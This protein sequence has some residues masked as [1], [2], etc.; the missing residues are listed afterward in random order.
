MDTP[1][2]TTRKLRDFQAYLA[3]KRYEF[4]DRFDPSDLSPKFIPYYESGQRIIVRLPG[5][6]E[7]RGYVHI[8]TGWKP[9]FL[10]IHRRSDL[11][12][13]TL[14]RDSYTIVGTVNLYY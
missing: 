7:E 5:G 11:G 14:L 10:L 6:E 4:G 9:A 3:R 13:A 1:I 2:T 8:T 12:S